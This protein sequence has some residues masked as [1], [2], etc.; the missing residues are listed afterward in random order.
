MSRL[1]FIPTIL[2]CL[3]I[4]LAAA[5]TASAATFCVADATCVGQQRATLG[6][7]LTDSRSNAEADTIRLGAGT[8]SVSLA[9]A[10]F[11]YTGTSIV[12]AG[13]T[14][15]KITVATGGT[16]VIRSG[17]VSGVAVTGN[18]GSYTGILQVIGGSLTSSS[19]ANT[20]PTGTNSAALLTSNTDL[21]DVWIISFDVGILH[22]LSANT[23][24]DD[25]LERLVVMAPTGI[26]I[27]D[28]QPASVAGS[29]VT[30]ARSRLSCVTCVV[31][32]SYGSGDAGGSAHKMLSIVDSVL[33][34]V[35]NSPA[36][37]AVS[38][39]LSTDTGRTQQHAMTTAILRST[40]TTSAGAPEA[41]RFE[42]LRNGPAPAPSHEVNISGTTVTGFTKTVRVVRFGLCGSSPNVCTF[43][44]AAANINGDFSAAGVASTAVPADT[45][46]LSGTN[47]VADPRFLSDGVGIRYDSPLRNRYPC[48]VL[49]DLF[50]ATSRADGMCDVGA[51]EYV[52]KAPQIN[53]ALTTPTT[54][55]VG[56]TVKAT[57]T[58]SDPNEGESAGLTYTWTAP[59]IGPLTG[60]TTSF[61]IPTG[62]GAGAYPVTLTVRDA[63]GATITQ[64]LTVRVTA[65]A[66]PAGPMSPPA[67]PTVTFTAPDGVTIT[68]PA[69]DYA[70]PA[71]TAAGSAPS[72]AQVSARRPVVVTVTSSEQGSASARLVASFTVRTATGALVTRRVSFT[73]RA[74][75]VT[76]GAPARLAFPITTTQR[77]A[78]LAKRRVGG[79]I[80]V[81]SGLVT[82]G[83]GN[84]RGYTKR[85]GGVLTLSVIPPRLDCSRSVPDVAPPVVSVP[86]GQT[87]TRTA[88]RSLRVVSNEGVRTSVRVVGRVSMLVT[89]VR[90]TVTYNLS[91]GTASSVRGGTLTVPLSFNVTTWRAMQAAARKPGA[92]MLGVRAYVVAKDASGNTRKVNTAVNVR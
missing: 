45:I 22:M 62:T 83:S 71:I 87:V 80:W 11:D 18:R 6:E 17:G 2:G 13:V 41:F 66:S 37:A 61:V 20:A 85:L 28:S 49:P 34:V 68:C 74:A 63:S 39:R 51:A 25:R 38:A 32:A 36:A 31:V 40:V 4:G 23:A 44:G 76:A 43:S 16:L 53:T 29:R 70:P 19:V 56:G 75:P 26:E 92:R 9:D 72:L 59:G 86:A 54:V 60:S 8:F 73:G 77:S 90:R 69:G 3:G 7:A 64:V 35:E 65:P 55:Q 84:A 30:I 12:G 1:R 27:E 50:G 89:G 88:P 58:A 10:G 42:M 57:A 48:G 46:A 78:L 82:D 15:S 81:A 79:I 5:S 91:S 33:N 67:S 24:V 14:A 47:T 21:D 52:A